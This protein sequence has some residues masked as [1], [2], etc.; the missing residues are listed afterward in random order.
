[1][2]WYTLQART[3]Y[4]SKII[5]EIE[6]KISESKITGVKEIFC[7]ENVVISMRNGKPYEKKVKVFAN[8]IFIDMDY[9][10]KNWH[11]FH[12][13]SGVNGFI[14]DKSKPAIT[15]G[16]EIESIKKNLENTL[17]TVERP[18]VEYSVGQEVRIKDGPFNSY[19]GKIKSID[20]AKNRANVLLI[21]FGSEAPVEVML[22][23]I[24]KVS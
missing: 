6:K 12:K 4:E 10:E 16:R 5:R 19:V 9:T 17:G 11:E 14:G 15:P 8:Y 20:I 24:E 22:D 18:Q 23:T 13:I 7:P 2:P 3:G 21:I 1:M